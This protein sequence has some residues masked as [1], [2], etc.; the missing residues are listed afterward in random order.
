MTLEC[1]AASKQHGINVMVKFDKT[2][3]S[4]AYDSNTL[5]Y[6][7]AQNSFILPLKDCNRKVVGPIIQRY[8]TLSTKFASQKNLTKTKFDVEV[9]NANGSKMKVARGSQFGNWLREFPQK[10]AY[11]N[12]EAQVSCKR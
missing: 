11:I 9:T 8:K 3:Y 12:A 7:Q 1:V 2:F 10:I 4:F 6:K 5:I